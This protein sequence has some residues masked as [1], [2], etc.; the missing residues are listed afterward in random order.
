MMS[1]HPQPESSNFFLFARTLLYLT[2]MAGTRAL[3]IFSCPKRLSEPIEKFGA[4][5]RPWGD[6]V[7]F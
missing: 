5:K 4:S 1:K 3:A 7:E 6:R 2:L